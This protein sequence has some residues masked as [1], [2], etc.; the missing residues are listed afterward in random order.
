M[1]TQRIVPGCD[2][3]FGVS[4]KAL[5][6]LCDSFAYFAVKS[7]LHEVQDPKPQRSPRGAAKIAKKTWLMLTRRS[8]VYLRGLCGL[9]SFDLAWTSS[10]S[11]ATSWTSNP[12]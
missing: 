1:N 4:H 7:F 8:F 3:S 12:S 11:R 2:A 6:E 9:F 10:H 5:C